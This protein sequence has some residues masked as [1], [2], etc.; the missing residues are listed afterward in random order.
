MKTR[1][2]CP[3]IPGLIILRFYSVANQSV[4][5]MSKKSVSRSQS[6]DDL[7]C[8]SFHA[9]QRDIPNLGNRIR[10]ERKHGVELATAPDRGFRSRVGRLLLSAW[11]RDICRHPGVKCP[12]GW[13]SNLGG[14][15]VRRR[16]ASRRNLSNLARDRRL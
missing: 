14:E 5:G 12:R 7:D 11:N 3:A 2:M 10:I 9:P 8:V 1:A 16:I 6:A 4:V 13:Q 15:C